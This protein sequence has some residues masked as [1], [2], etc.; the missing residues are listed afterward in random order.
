MKQRSLIYGFLFV[1]FTCF[2]HY[3]WC[4]DT[5]EAENQLGV[6]PGGDLVSR[7]VWRG[8]DCFNAPAIQPYIFFSY[9][10]FT[11]GTW[12]SIALAKID[13]L[14]K[15]ETDLYLAY[16]YKFITVSV[17]DYYYFDY[18]TINNQCFQYGDS[19]KHLLEGDLQL[20]GPEKFPIKF[21]AAYNFY[22][23]D[24]DNSIY[25]ELGYTINLEETSVD[26]FLGY[27]PYSGLY[28]PDPAIMNAGLTITKTLNI[29]QKFEIPFKVSLISNPRLQNIFLVCT[30]SI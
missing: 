7:Y 26:L 2:L 4:Q 9:K 21:L 28:A 24:P 13:S 15:Y 10:N 22:G 18:T 25:L 27:T 16:T 20:T 19:T 8:M 23:D 1:V 5:T 3:S 6:A 11:V 30:V 17:W 12:G 29:S 14:T